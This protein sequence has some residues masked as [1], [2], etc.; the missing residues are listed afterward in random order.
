LFGLPLVHIQFGAASSENGPARGWI[1]IGTGHSYGILFALGANAC[2]GISVGA[3][4]TGIICVGSVSVG[5]ISLGTFALGVFA[6]GST[7]FG[8]YAMGPF[9]A[10]WNVAVG[11][12]AVAHDL[13]AGG[14]AL[15]AHA[16]DAISNAW[17]LRHR[18]DR[19]F[20]GALASIAVLTLL[21]G[22]LYYFALRRR[23]RSR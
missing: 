9:A 23:R 11:G 20:V 3:I 4:S 6:F 15:A 1:A 19:V 16:N 7:A 18:V 21:P 22:S 14:F 10:A 12:I 5:V 2:G 8:L 17:M 13:A